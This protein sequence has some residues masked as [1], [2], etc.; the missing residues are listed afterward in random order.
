MA[1]IPVYSIQGRNGGWRLAGGGRTDLS[2]LERRRGP[3][4]VPRRRAVVGRA[5]PQLKAALRKLVRALPEPLRADAEAASGA[6]HVDPSTW[7]QAAGERRPPPVHLD[8]LQDAVV[9]GRQVVLDYVGRDG[10]TSSRTVDPLG[11]AAKGSVWYL[12]A[13]TA[14]GQRTVPDRPGHGGRRC[15]RRRSSG[16]PGST[17]RRR[18]DR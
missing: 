12:V 1:G 15:W 8:V 9:A 18:G 7:D 4:A 2:G 5:R 6:V 13:G 3:G 14:D 16:R 11:V 10:A 17:S